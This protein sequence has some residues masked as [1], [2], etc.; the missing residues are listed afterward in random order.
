SRTRDQ[1][2][3]RAS[4]GRQLDPDDRART[5]THRARANPPR[6]HAPSLSSIAQVARRT[7]LR[8]ADVETVRVPHA[9]VHGARIRR[10]ENPRA[11]VDDELV[12]VRAGRERVAAGPAAVD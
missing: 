10:I 3:Q 2:L 12:L 9:V 5:G 1:R 6:T 4:S 8:H 7:E 11:A